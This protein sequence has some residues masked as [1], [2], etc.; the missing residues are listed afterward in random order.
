MPTPQEFQTL[1]GWA[2]R[3]PLVQF[4]YTHILSKKNNAPAPKTV[5]SDTEVSP[6]LANLDQNA[7]IFSIQIW[8][9]S[10]QEPKF[11]MI[12]NLIAQALSPDPA[13][14]VSPTATPTPIETLTPAAT[15]TPIETLTPAATPLPPP[16]QVPI[17]AV[18]TQ[19]AQT[20]SGL[21]DRTNCTRSVNPIWTQAA[22]C[23][24]SVVCRSKVNRT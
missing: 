23:D 24:R 16:V 1:V 4:S 14:T 5:S 6:S 10:L 9:K 13:A 21:T 17:Q 3:P 7:I 22:G 12:I 18:Q 8:K 2:S 11:I 15:P 19:A 20:V